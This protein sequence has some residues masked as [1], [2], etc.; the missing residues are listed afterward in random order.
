MLYNVAH[1]F[2]PLRDDDIAEYERGRNLRLSEAETGE[3][4]ERD[5]MA[6][7]GDAFD[8]AVAL[9]DAR[10][11]G[12]ENYT[13]SEE[14]KSKVPVKHKA[15]AV[16]NALL[17]TQILPLPLVGNN[18][19]FP[20]DDEDDASTIRLRVLF[21]DQQMVTEHVLRTPSADDMREYRKLMSR[22]LLVPGEALNQQEQRIPSRARGLGRLYDKV[23]ERTSGYSGRVPLHHRM[24]VVLEHFKGEA[25]SLGN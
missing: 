2:A 25:G 4:D 21:N 22:A 20:V 24:R 11:K 8:A 5:A 3:S 14:W 7:T 1:I 17:A 10:I 23:V 15:F 19:A 18:A 16:Q 9:W 13:E 6:I 12:V